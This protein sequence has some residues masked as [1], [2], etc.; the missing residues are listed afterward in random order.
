MRK[1]KR[2]IVQSGGSKLGTFVVGVYYADTDGSEVLFECSPIIADKI[3]GLWNE[4]SPV[5][6]TNLI[7]QGIREELIKIEEAIRDCN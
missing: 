2:D 3:I 6:K 7:L 4:K 1:L 5:A